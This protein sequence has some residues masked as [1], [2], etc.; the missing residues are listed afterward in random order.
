MAAEAVLS[1]TAQLVLL[2]WGTP[3]GQQSSSSRGGMIRF[4]EVKSK[5]NLDGD[6]QLDANLKTNL[7]NQSGASKQALCTDSLVRS[8][9]YVRRKREKARGF[10][11]RHFDCPKKMPHAH[12][13]KKSRGLDLH[14]M[15]AVLGTLHRRRSAV[16]QSLALILSRRAPSQK[17]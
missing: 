5:P 9:P 6:P 8:R 12:P 13:K 14:S 11:F 7:E 4:I 2:Q 15:P 17:C 3:H 1:N 16:S 10:K